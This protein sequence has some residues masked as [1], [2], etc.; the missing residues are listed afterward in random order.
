MIRILTNL[1]LFVIAVVGAV[2]AFRASLEH[3]KLDAEHRR[4]TLAVGRLPIE[5]P[6]KWHVTA[7]ET[8]D[9][10]DFRWRIYAPANVH[11]NWRYATGRGGSGSS[12]GSGRS[13]PRNE[14]ARVRFKRAPDGAWQMWLK[15]GHGSSFST[16]GNPA[17][18]RVLEDP[19]KLI[20]HQLG[21][22]EIVVADVDEVMT[23]LKIEVPDDVLKSFEAE[24]EWDKPTKQIL[25]FELGSQEAFAKREQK[26]P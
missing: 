2:S 16:V 3:R 23:L 19:S 5:D 25:L 1:I 13:A 21:K 20:I 18:L 17:W 15:S 24:K 6:N 26:T 10:L 8:E 12:M 7:T 9:P 4:L 14:V 22:D 11:W